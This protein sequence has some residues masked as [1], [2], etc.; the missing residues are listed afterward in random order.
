[1]SKKEMNI[2]IANNNGKVRLVGF[3]KTN[4]KY[5][6]TEELQNAI[7]TNLIT[8]ELEKEYKEEFLNNFERMLEKIKEEAEEYIYLNKK[9]KNSYFW[10][11]P[12]KAEKRRE[13][14]SNNWTEFEIN[15]RYISLY[16]NFYLHVS[17]SYFYV[18]KKVMINNKK[19][20]LRAV[21]QV[22]KEIELLKNFIKNYKES[23]FYK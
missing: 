18:Y 22:L 2:E 16:L 6:N 23:R 17:C 9:F 19:T 1:M 21:R 8:T 7:I 12:G 15:N 11:T 3:T 14:E 10:E 20:N 4:F 5:F 13:I